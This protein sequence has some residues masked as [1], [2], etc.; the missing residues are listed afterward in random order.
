MMRTPS[1]LT[2][3]DG[4]FDDFAFIRVHSHYRDAFLGIHKATGNMVSIVEIPPPL[5]AP[6]QPAPEPEPEPE[7]DAT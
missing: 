1:R 4:T 7:P 6:A 5:A 2:R 3:H